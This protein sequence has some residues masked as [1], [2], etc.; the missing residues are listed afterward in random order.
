MKLYELADQH[1]ALQALADTEAEDMEQAIR[2]TLEGVEGEFQ[3][4]AVALVKVTKNMDADIAALDAEI[5]RLQQ[6]KRALENNQAR[7]RDY[8]RENMER[9][10]IRKISCPL[11]TISCVPG[12]QIAEVENES[13]LPCQ[14]VRVK[15]E[16]DK[17]AIADALKAGEDVPGARLAQAKSSIRIR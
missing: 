2:D 15:R 11:F 3:E 10:G 6:R 1:K 8:L 14:Y 17:K 5:K 4:K 7:M 16:P 9:T 13:A 12:R